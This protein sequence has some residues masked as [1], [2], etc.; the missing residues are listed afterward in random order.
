MK[1]K[2]PPEGFKLNE[3][4]PWEIREGKKASQEGNKTS[5]ARAGG[6]E[7]ENKWGKKHTTKRLSGKK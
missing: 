3:K 5:G 4:R 6:S 2:G 7:Q 1:K